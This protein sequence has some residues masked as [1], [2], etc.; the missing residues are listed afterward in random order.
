MEQMAPNWDAMAEEQD[1]HYL[2]VQ[3]DLLKTLRDATLGEGWSRE[4]AE[5][6]YRQVWAKLRGLQAQVSPAQLQQITRAYQMGQHAA[7]QALMQL[8]LPLQEAIPAAF[9]S[10]NF[11]AV[12]ALASD[13]VASQSRVLGLTGFQPGSILRDVHDYLWE[14]TRQEVGTGIGVGRGAEDIGRLIRGDYAPGSGEY[15]GLLA[16][17]KAGGKLQDFSSLPDNVVA[18]VS[19]HLN[20]MA[21]FVDRGGNTWSLHRYSM[22]AARTGS[23][24]AYVAG[25]VNAMQEHGITLVEVSSH[26][27]LCPI[28][29]P[30]EGTVGTM[31]DVEKAGYPRLDNRC[32]FHPNCLHILNPWMKGLNDAGP[33]PKEIWNASP[34]ALRKQMQETEHGRTLLDFAGRGFTSEHEV[35]GFI[36]DGVAPSEVKGPRWHDPGIEKRRL[37]ATEELLKTGNTRTY[38]QAMASQ[39]GQ[40]MRDEKKGIFAVKPEMPQGVLPFP[41]TGHGPQGSPVSGALQL[42]GEGTPRAA[43]IKHAVDLI[44]QVHGAGPIPLTSVIAKDFG[45]W[46]PHGGYETIGAPEIEVNTNAAKV[47]PVMTVLHEVGHLLDQ[48][49]LPGQG[50]ATTHNVPAI[51]DWWKAVYNSKQ[52]ATL[53]AAGEHSFLKKEELFARS[54]AQFIAGRSLDPAALAELASMRKLEGIKVWN[55]DDFQPIAK[56]LEDLC[57]RM[58]WLKK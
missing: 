21:G 9:S 10:V 23:Q 16:Q 30:W 8:R 40:R 42:P 35:K 19:D 17:L 29:R 3:A 1:A 32:P 37:A 56:A 47:H 12:H 7:R 24:R 27:T 48:H 2:R 6:L 31:G 20:Q 50:Y 36:A 54:Y 26:G 11:R 5:L 39:T 45:P 18:A 44:D 33:A 58:K 53:K 25:Q 13:V 4:R 34:A 55:P 41:D 49:G 15:S 46:Y 51:A 43:E 14:I 22:M 52:Y 38:T 28:C 57:L